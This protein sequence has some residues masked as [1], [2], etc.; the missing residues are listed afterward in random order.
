MINLFV[1]ILMVLF[2]GIFA[3]MSLPLSDPDQSD[4][5]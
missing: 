1:L 2:A 5:K 3:L 4:D